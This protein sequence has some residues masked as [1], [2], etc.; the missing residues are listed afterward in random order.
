M[1]FRL[2][3]RISV[4]QG[5]G[6]YG[7]NKT[8]KADASKMLQGCTV[9]RHKATNMLQGSIMTTAFTSCYGIS[10]YCWYTDAFLYCL[11]LLP[12]SITGKKSNEYPNKSKLAVS[13][14]QIQSNLICCL[15]LAL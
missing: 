11:Y 4:G 3:F 13:S 8:E 1:A 10:M 9:Q 2:P 12:P 14:K 7:I 6:K 15:L 5:E